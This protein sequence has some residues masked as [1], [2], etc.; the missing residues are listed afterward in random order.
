MHSYLEDW[1]L[2]AETQASATAQQVLLVRWTKKLKCD[3]IV[4][5]Y[6]QPC[7]YV[8]RVHK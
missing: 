4:V 8:K 3:K 5:C 6:N 7:I 1:I 2:L